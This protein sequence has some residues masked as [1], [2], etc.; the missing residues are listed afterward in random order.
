MLIFDNVKS[1]K[2]L[3]KL[4]RASKVRIYLTC[5]IITPDAHSSAIL[6]ELESASQRGVDVIIYGRDES[7]VGNLDFGKEKLQNVE[8][9]TLLPSERKKKVIY[10]ITPNRGCHAKLFV[11][12]DM[13]ISTDRNISDQYFKNKDENYKAVDFVF[14]SKILGDRIY[15]YFKDQE[16]FFLKLGDVTFGLG[17]IQKYVY[18]ILRS[19][20][21]VRITT[22]TLFPS[23]ELQKI[24]IDG[25]HEILTGKTIGG[26]KPFED[27]YEK[28]L[29]FT[30]IPKQTYIVN[31]HLHYKFILAQKFFAHGSFNLDLCSENMVDEQIIVCPRIEKYEIMYTLLDKEY[32]LQ[33]KKAK[34]IKRTSFTPIGWVLQQIG[35]EVL[36]RL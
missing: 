3:K 32:T 28:L 35:G 30:G 29:Y 13:I 16:T 14:K 36:K 5:F 8:F 20:D 11:L 33:K 23:M 26:S 25:D 17:R 27:A 2:N 6:D 18:Q 4:I 12:D 15:R 34:V 9:V 24:I 10:W 21:N 31:S 19:E 1:F 22:A 7:L